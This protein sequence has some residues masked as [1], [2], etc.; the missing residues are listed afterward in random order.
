VQRDLHG[1]AVVQVKA[2]LSDSQ[3]SAPEILL[4]AEGMQRLKGIE[5][6]VIAPD[7]DRKS[8]PGRT[9]VRTSMMNF[10]Q[11]IE[12]IQ[13]INGIP[14]FDEQTMRDLRKANCNKLFWI[15][16]L[17]DI[18]LLCSLVLLR[19]MGLQTYIPNMSWRPV[20]SI[21]YDMYPSDS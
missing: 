18:A 8:P 2:W 16:G 7:W 21:R 17:I 4:S 11:K 13:R 3:W 14:G 19:C 5:P 1:N 20:R 12:T 9:P 15:T 10:V 6:E